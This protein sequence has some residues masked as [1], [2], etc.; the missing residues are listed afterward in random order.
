VRRC[1]HRSPPRS[2]S[3]GR[4]PDLACTVFCSEPIVPWCLL[5]APCPS[6]AASVA[7]P[8]GPSALGLDGANRHRH[9]L[10]SLN[11]MACLLPRDTS[12]FIDSQ[13]CHRSCCLNQPLPLSLVIVVSIRPHSS[14]LRTRDRQAA[15]HPVSPTY[16][17]VL[18]RVPTIGGLFQ[19]DTRHSCSLPM[20]AHHPKLAT[21]SCAPCLPSLF[22]GSFLLLSISSPFPNTSS[23]HHSG[24]IVCCLSVVPSR[25]HTARVSRDAPPLDRLFNSLPVLCVPS[26]PLLL[27]ASP[28][29]LLLQRSK[30]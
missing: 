6:P 5:S 14:L 7:Q 21:P 12:R 23:P 4:W 10:P 20:H 24:L 19:R 16:Q 9:P 22:P 17:K 11:P 15:S 29:A 8:G 3:C 2:A 30:P 27:V 26:T 1:V 28:A 25:F 18:D 13:Q